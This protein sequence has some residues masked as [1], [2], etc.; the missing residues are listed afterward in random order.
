MGGRFVIDV[1]VQLAAGAALWMYDEDVGA[2]KICF[3]LDSLRSCCT[4]QTVKWLV[5]I[6]DTRRVFVEIRH[7]AAEFSTMMYNT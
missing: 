5:T 2:P 7:H 6:V 4:L 1:P 3:F